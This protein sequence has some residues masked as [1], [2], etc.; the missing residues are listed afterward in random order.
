MLAYLN[1]VG[2]GIQAVIG[3]ISVRLDLVWWSV[4]IHFLPSMLLIWLATLLWIRTRQPDD[5]TVDHMLDSTPRLL[6]IAATINIALVLITGTLVAGAG[7]HSG[8][9]DVGMKGRLGVNLETMAHI[10]SWM[11]YLYLALVIITLVFILRNRL[12]KRVRN[13][14]LALLV[15]IFVQAFVGIMQFQLGVPRWSVPIHVVLSGTITAVNAGLYSYSIVLRGGRA[16]STGST[17][18]DAQR[19]A[20][21][22]LKASSSTTAD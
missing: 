19:E 18:G 3:G 7:E 11:T 17:N 15:L 13:T 5:G 22:H 21:E 1:L 8:D 12:D 10:H 14:G 2:I 9:A 16:T 6:T 4:A 20:R